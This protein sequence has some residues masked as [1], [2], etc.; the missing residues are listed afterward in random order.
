MSET[1]T[2]E[3]VYAE[4]NGGL[5]E[6]ERLLMSWSALPVQEDP[7]PNGKGSPPQDHPWHFVSPGA[8]WQ[9]R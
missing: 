6:R 4:F 3:E 1:T 9:K 8:G 7:D 2:D 5:S